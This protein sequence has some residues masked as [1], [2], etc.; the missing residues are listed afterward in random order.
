VGVITGFASICVNDLEVQFDKDTP[1][2]D[3]GQP[4]ALAQLA[5]G[6]IVSIRAQNE[7]DSVVARHI[8][9]MH[10]AVGPL[11][12]VDHA[13]GEFKVLGQAARAFNPADVAQLEVG[14][15]VRVSGHRL[16]LG[17]I[18]ASRI[19]A[20]PPAPQVQL[21]GTVRATDGTGFSLEGT[22]VRLDK[23]LAAEPFAPGTE[24]LVRGVW[25]GISLQADQVQSNPTSASLGA[26]RQVVAE[27]YIRALTTKGMSLGHT[28]MALDPHVQVMGGT[29]GQL[30]VNQRVQIRGQV[31]ADLRITVERIEFRSGG[32]RGSG[33]SGDDGADS[34][35]GSGTDD[36]SGRHGGSD[37]SGGSGKSG[38]TESGSSGKTESSGS[39]GS[40]GRSSNSG[41]S[42]SSGSS[43]GGKK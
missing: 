24:V 23:A 25:N 1:L 29:V 13:T 40:S 35:R 39:S 14:D 41:S 31:G 6:Q 8:A 15:W 2:S 42:G 12:A 17:E 10:A 21:M 28:T 19:E 22:P 34:P 5:V 37:D 7:G 32:G 18:A 33:G 36:S 38:S 30:A 43:G 16:A 26:V 27:G 9:V 3:N 11:D 20:I 4:A